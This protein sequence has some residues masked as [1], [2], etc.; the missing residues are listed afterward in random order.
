MV[1]H[2]RRF[3]RGDKYENIDNIVMDFFVLWCIAAGVWIYTMINRRMRNN[4]KYVY[5]LIAVNVLNMAIQIIAII[6]RYNA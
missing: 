3:L 1:T 6:I 2:K 5:P 4:F